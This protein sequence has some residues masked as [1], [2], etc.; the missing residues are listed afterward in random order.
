M[1]LSALTYIFYKKKNYDRKIENNFIKRQILSVNC[2]WPLVIFKLIPFPTPT[3]MSHIA[4]W[5]GEILLQ[6]SFAVNEW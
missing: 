2:G 5:R 6:V 3:K 4:W 1:V